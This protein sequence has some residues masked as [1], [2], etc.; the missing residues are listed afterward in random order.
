MLE[1]IVHVQVTLGKAETRRPVLLPVCHEG[2]ATH[3]EARSTSRRVG[4]SLGLR[5]S[6]GGASGG[7]AAGRGRSSRGCHGAGGGGPAVQRAEEVGRRHHGLVPQCDVELCLGW[8]RRLEVV[9]PVH[10]A[11]AGVQGRDGEL[12]ADDNATLQL[13]GIKCC[14]TKCYTVSLYSLLH[15][16][17]EH[18]QAPHLLALA[19]LPERGHHNVL[20]RLDGSG[21]DGS[22]EHRALALDWEGVVEGEH[23][24]ACRVPL[25][26]HKLVLECLD[27][28]VHADGRRAIVWVCRHAGKGQVSAKFCGREGCPQL[29]DDPLQCLLPLLCRDHVHLVQDDDKLVG[30]NLGNHQTLGGLCLDALV[31]IDHQRAEVDD[32]CTTDDGPDQRRMPWAVHEAELYDLVALILEAIRRVAGEGGETQVQSD[33]ALLRL[34]VLVQRRCRSDSREHAA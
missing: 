28:L 8:H 6:G 11:D 5:D 27:E 22:G 17:P 29:L 32:L 9:E 24:G 7:L 30:K 31:H 4:G 2:S 16:L 18:L 34:R 1:E 14:Y 12:L 21:E 26:E 25:R 13:L 23:E 10:D 15:R 33:A 3:G 20:L 19:S